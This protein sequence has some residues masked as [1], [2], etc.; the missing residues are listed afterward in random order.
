MK[1]RVETFVNG[2]DESPHLTSKI[3]MHLGRREVKAGPHPNVM[4]TNSRSSCISKTIVLEIL[5]TRARRT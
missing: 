5:K 4:A 1:E 3:L 2:D